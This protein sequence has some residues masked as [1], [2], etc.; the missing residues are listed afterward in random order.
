MS[1]EMQ[2]RVSAL[3]GGHLVAVAGEVDMATAPRLAETL[4]QFAN[5]SV[6][7]DLSNV[8]FIDSSGLHALIAAQRHI[9]RRHSR[10]I[11]QGVTSNIRQLF[12]ISGLDVILGA[13]PIGND[14][15]RQD[16]R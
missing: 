3:N 9:E 16:E 8:T 7:V 2:C 5:G 4:V 14:T 12:E 10:L 15:H 6:T 11:M 13:D 1:D